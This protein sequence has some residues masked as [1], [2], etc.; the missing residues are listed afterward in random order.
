MG[1]CASCPIKDGPCVAQTQGHEFVCGMAERGVDTDLKWISFKSTAAP[2]PAYPALKPM[3]GN[4]ARSAVSFVASG[5]ATVDRAEFDRRRAVCQS[6]DQ[7]DAAQDRCK[8][9]GCSLAVKPWGRAMEC[10]LGRWDQPARQG[11]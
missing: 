6:C 10:P 9:C 1:K 2:A 11:D 7:F 5:C 3:V 4:L 8:K